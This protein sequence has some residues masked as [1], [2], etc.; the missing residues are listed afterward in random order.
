MLNIQQRVENE[1][2]IF[3]SS[4]YSSCC[5]YSGLAGIVAVYQNYKRRLTLMTENKLYIITLLTTFLGILL[6]LLG[7]ILHEKHENS[8]SVLAEYGPKFILCIG[9]LLVIIPLFYLM[10]SN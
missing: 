6:L 3:S 10:L 7:Y 1:G 2:Y 4:N 9:G 5:K 8:T